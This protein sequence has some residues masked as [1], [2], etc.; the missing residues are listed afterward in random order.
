MINMLGMDHGGYLERMRPVVTAF[1]DGKAKLNVIFNAIVKVYKNGEPVKLSKRSGNLIT[2]KEMVEQ[3]GPGAV[4]FFMLTRDSKSQLDF[5]FAKVVEQS[6]DNPVF[7]V[8][9]AHARCYS[10]LRTAEEQE[11]VAWAFS[12]SPSPEQLALLTA[13]LELELIRLLAGWPRLVESA[14]LGY[15]PHRFAFYLH[16]VASAFH[17]LWNSGNGENTLR[18]IQKDAIDLTAARLSLVRACAIVIASG[19][20]VLG[21]EPLKEMR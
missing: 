15:E 8:Q 4:R 20:E 5:D 17:G 19:L 10:V 12:E 18:F 16:E 1:S 9:Y 11:G 14:A 13:P 21:V 2:L 7:Y 3:V 6:K